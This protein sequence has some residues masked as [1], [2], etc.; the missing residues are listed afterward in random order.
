MKAYILVNKRASECNRDLLSFLHN[1]TNSIKKKL[2]NIRHN[3]F[4]QYYNKGTHS[5]LKLK[6][7]P[8]LLVKNQ[9]IYGKSAIK[10]YILSGTVKP[11]KSSVKDTSNDLQSFWKEEMYSKEDNVDTD[12]SIMD[13]IRK[14]AL[15]ATMTRNE[16]TN[17]RKKKP[18]NSLPTPRESNIETEPINT[19]NIA[20][21]VD[22]PMMAKFWANQEYTPGT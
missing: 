13:D 20:D 16:Q 12:E 18:R 17:S 15:D 2:A 21:M 11:N 7:L 3:K 4:V 5:K 9:K 1:N 6:S 8:A 10:K 14:R 22:D 19:D